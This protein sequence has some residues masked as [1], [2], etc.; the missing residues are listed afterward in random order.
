MLRT[1]CVCC[2]LVLSLGC[3]SAPRVFTSMANCVLSLDGA[4]A[5][6]CVDET[7]KPYI[8]LLMN[9]RDLVC[10]KRDQFKTFDETCH[11]K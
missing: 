6:S 11:S 10:F 8:L 5:F 4:E 9:A 2:S 3:A 1:L 7:G